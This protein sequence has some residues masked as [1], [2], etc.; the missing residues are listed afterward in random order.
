MTSVC[1]ADEN[2]KP[3]DIFGRDRAEVFFWKSPS[4]FLSFPN[5]FPSTFYFSSALDEVL[6]LINTLYFQFI[7]GKQGCCDWRTSTFDH[8]IFVF[9]RYCILSRLLISV[10]LFLCVTLCVWPLLQWSLSS[11]SQ[12]CMSRSVFTVLVCLLAFSPDR[13]DAAHSLWV[14]APQS[15]FFVFECLGC[16]FKQEITVQQC[17][18][19]LARYFRRIAT[20]FRLQ[21]AWDAWE[22]WSIP[23]AQGLHVMLRNWLLDQACSVCFLLGNFSTQCL[24]TGFAGHAHFAVYGCFLQTSSGRA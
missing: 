16:T 4:F 18:C 5:F 24:S 3:P 20:L 19:R 6:P 13:C 17:T 1:F 22:H 23:R 9:L 14:L 10:S 15:R 21:H 8:V 12:C 2:L 7:P 11:F